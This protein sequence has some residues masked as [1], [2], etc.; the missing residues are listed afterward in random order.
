MHTVEK[1]ILLNDI[2]NSTKKWNKYGNKMY[3]EIERIVKIVNNLLKSHNGFIIK[4]IGDSFMMA[5]DNLIDSIDFAIAFQKKITDSKSLLPTQLEFRTGIYYGTVIEKK[6]SIQ[7][8]LVK[9]F[10]GTVI[11]T[12]SRLESKVSDSNSIAIGIRKTKD[13]NS[14]L[15]YLKTQ[16]Y[17]YEVINYRR[18]CNTRSFKNVKHPNKCKSI[19]KLK[20]LNKN[21]KVLKIIRKTL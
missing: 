15:D 5:F 16:N 18:K 13:L 14:I 2:I 21:I 19:K 3:Y 12:A 9:D 11:N 4:M 20:G 6:M 1:V 10:F 7:K 8:C 17:T